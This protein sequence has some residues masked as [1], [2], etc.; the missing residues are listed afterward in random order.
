MDREELVRIRVLVV[1]LTIDQRRTEGQRSQSSGPGDAYTPS[2]SHVLDLESPTVKAIWSQYRQQE[3]ETGIKLDGSIDIVRKFVHVTYGSTLISQ[4]ME[5]I[6]HRYQRIY[7]EPLELVRLTDQSDCDFDPEYSVN[8][9]LNSGNVVH[10]FIPPVVKSISDSNPNSNPGRL[11]LVGNDKIAP[12]EQ[13]HI[14]SKPKRRKSSLVLENGKL[15][16][17]VVLLAPDISSDFDSSMVDVDP[18]KHSSPGESSF[19]PLD[20]HGQHTSQVQSYQNS[21]LGHTPL[22]VLIDPKTTLLAPASEPNLQIPQ[23]P[24]TRSTR[25][26]KPRPPR[27]RKPISPSNLTPP[28]ASNIDESVLLERARQSLVQAF[29]IPSSLP[30][31]SSS[32]SLPQ[33]LHNIKSNPKNNRA[34]V[35]R[36]QSGPGKD[37][38]SLRSSPPP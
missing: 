10:A 21:H 30:S 24:Q 9:V 22:Q 11:E 29:S 4:L 32:Q 7:H 16:P 3:Y 1:R 28:M 2:P 13:L 14:T 6:G 19:S 27:R 12:T 8:L 26:R 34:R 23:K 33:L 35:T 5:E 31:H 25:I 38:S 17:R 20:D 36:S 15:D 37:L 18:Q